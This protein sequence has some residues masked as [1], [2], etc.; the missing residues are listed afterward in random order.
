M[1]I[2]LPGKEAA[3]CSATSYS[4]DKKGKNSPVIPLIYAMVH[5]YGFLDHLLPCSPGRSKQYQL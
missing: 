5:E 3:V 1:R 2:L 4:D